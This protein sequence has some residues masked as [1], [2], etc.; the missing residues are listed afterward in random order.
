MRN[1]LF[2]ICLQC[3]IIKSSF[4]QTKPLLRS[5]NILIILADDMSKSAGAYGDNV[6]K[7]PG[8]DSLAKEGI[9]FERA[10]CTASS[11]TPSRA[12]ILTGRYP[13]ELSE[14][15]NLYGPLSVSYPTYT[16]LLAENGYSI[17]LSGKGWGPG[18]FT[19]GGYKENPAG[20]KFESFEQFIAQLPENSPFCFWLGSTD[21]H[22]PYSSDLT[23]R[24]EFN[25]VELKIPSW[26]PDNG[27]IRED[28]LDYY[29]EAKRFDE[30]VE[31]AIALL[32]SI[33]KY[34]NT[35]IIVSSDNGM[36]FPRA[37][38]NV[39]DISTNIPL[40]MR[41]G[42]HFKKGTRYKELVS[43]ADLAP[44]VLEVAKINAPKSMTGKSLLPLLVSNKSDARFNTVFVE[45]ERHAN[46][47]KNSL[48]Y[49]MRAIR[50]KNFL[51]IQNL[52]PDRWPAGDP[53]FFREPGPFGDIDDG[54]TKQ[55]LIDN[56]NNP[57]FK[58]QVGWSLEKRPFEELYD[59]V[60]DPDALNNLAQ[61][62]KYKK[63]KKQLSEQLT[64]WRKK[65]GDPSLDGSKNIFDTYPYDDGKN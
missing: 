58:K 30:T 7:T 52:K 32:K 36:P 31:K 12:S 45:R 23:K 25:K 47:R 17:G 6:I 11:C 22:R 53:D 4:E 42:N 44:T 51:Y 41:W 24:T 26:L 14:G 8:I 55:F 48:S 60:N 5:P 15:A 18:N 13:H 61:K 29:A 2:L 10:F 19:T 50:T 1:F 65:T 57:K 40:V 46:I 62:E 21:P 3:F 49:P 35:F 34:D 54:Y 20:P 39:Y 9:V 33:G 64:T 16:R 28:F 59:I 27:K 37:K 43:L 38:A 56:R 63:I